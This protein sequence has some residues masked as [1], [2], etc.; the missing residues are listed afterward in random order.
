MIVLDTNLLSEPW[1]PEPAREVLNWLDGSTEVFA[2]SAVSVGELLNGMHLLPV[3]RRRKALSEAIDNL[4]ES[5]DGAV[6]SYDEPAARAYAELNERSR[7]AG[8]PISVEDGMIAGIC[9][10]NG[11]TLA[12]RNVKDFEGMGIDLVN[13]WD[14]ESPAR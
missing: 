14:A 2:L 7:K 9:V 5:F 3:G 11:A 6:L 10:A 13:P 1:R 4:L 8:R 12:T